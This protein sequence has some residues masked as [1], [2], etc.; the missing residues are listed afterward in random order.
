MNNRFVRHKFNAKKTEVDGITFA[1][2]KEAAY[3]QTLRLR[4]KAGEVLGFFRQVPIDLPGGIIYRMDFLVFYTDGSC[5]G[6]EIKG[7]ETPEWKLKYKLLQ[8]FYPWFELKVI[9]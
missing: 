5:E 2:K 8:E 1:S 6:I 9:K 3:Y 4:Q 7:H